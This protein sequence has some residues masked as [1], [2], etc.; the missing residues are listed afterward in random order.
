MQRE[1]GTA[2]T[3]GREALPFSSRKEIASG[4]ATFRNYPTA[5]KPSLKDHVFRSEGNLEV[6][7]KS[8]PLALTSGA[9]SHRCVFISPPLLGHFFCHIWCFP[10][11][12]PVPSCH[13]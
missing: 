1:L 8:K 4:L 11:T 5:E 12:P 2:R 3:S 13:V 6:G 10:L 9:P 7:A